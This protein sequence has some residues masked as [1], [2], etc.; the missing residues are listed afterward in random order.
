MRNTETTKGE[1]TKKRDI[2]GIGIQDYA[3]R[4]G[5]DTSEKVKMVL[6]GNYSRRRGK[7]G[8]WRSRKGSWGE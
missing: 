3:R 6:R 7:H 1:K 8:K 5:K 4:Q 2:E